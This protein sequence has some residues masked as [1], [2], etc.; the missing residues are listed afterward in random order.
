MCGYVPAFHDFPP[1]GVRSARTQKVK[2]LRVYIFG[3]FWISPQKCPSTGQLHCFDSGPHRLGPLGNITQQLQIWVSP[4]FLGS[5]PSALV[6]CAYTLSGCGTDLGSRRVLGAV[7]ANPL[8]RCASAFGAA[9]M[10]WH[11]AAWVRGTGLS[12]CHTADGSGGKPVP[13][14]ETLTESEHSSESFGAFGDHQISVS[15]SHG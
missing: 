3:V 13:S 1:L 12:V 8:G 15:E 7:Y 9:R 6:M 11:T 2:K 4:G 5:P 10:S 14:G